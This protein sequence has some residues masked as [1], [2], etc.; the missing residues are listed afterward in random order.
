MRQATA[1]LLMAL[2]T[3]G[4]MSAANEIGMVTSTLD[5]V[6]D[7]NDAFLRLTG[8]TR[9]DLEAG[10]VHWRLLTAPEWTSMDDSAVDELR[11]TGSYGPHLKEYL[12]PDGTRL[13]VEVTSALLSP[14]PPSWVTFIRDPAAQP[15]SGTLADSAERLAVLA[16]ELGR[17]VTVTDV[18]R[19]LTR[20]VRQAMGAL[21][22]TI[23]VVDLAGQS[24]HPVLADEIPVPIA[25]GFRAFDTELD[26]PSTRA[27]RERRMGF[28]PDTQTTDKVFPH[29]A[30]VRAA[31]AV[32]SAMAVPLIAGAEITGVLT[33]YW[34]TPRELSPAERSFTDAVAGYAAQALARAQLFEAEQAA[35]ARLQALQV[36]T[37]GLATAVTSEQIAEVLVR[38]GMGI[39]AAHGVVAVLD[40]P[41]DHLRTWTTA[42]FPADIARI[43]A[44]IPVSSADD[45]PIGWTMRTGQTLIL[46]SL[47]EISARHPQVAYTHEATGTSS[48]LSV[49]VHA[50]GRTIGALAFGFSPE[51]TPGDDVI[52]VAE[53][54]AGLALERA[55]LYEIE[56]AAAH[57]LQQALL[58]TIPTGLPGVSIGAFYR[59]AE[60]GNEVG[61][62]WYDVFELP[63]GAVGDV[64]GHD[65]A[66]A[67]AMGRLQLLLRYTALGGAGPAG[68]LDALEAACPDLTGT[69]YAT[70]AY[71]EYDPA[72]PGGPHLTYAC[73]EHPPPLLAD[74]ETVRFLEGGR[75]GAL[76]FG[77]SRT[78]ARIAVPRPA[79]LV[80]Y[81][82]GLVERRGQT[83][84]AGFGRLA[85]AVAG[86]P[87]GG[88]TR[89]A[90]DRLLTIMTGTEVLADDV[91][92]ICI[93]LNGAQG[94]RARGR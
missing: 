94:R 53:T 75:S 91:A 71:A 50:G 92:L 27:W 57:Q 7:A 24:M 42:N 37:A 83:I 68:V 51:G 29:L 90:C 70:V 20:H 46:A 52:Q 64:V 87:D 82:D 34:S 55:R 21:G 38:E 41:G 74:G 15:D 44:R 28:Y 22:S 8:N 72:G 88:D 40:P 39:V 35:R 49:P 80:L 65:L 16:G 2:A 43:Y 25:Q 32:H 69:D 4:R 31:S 76:G 47:A 5:G 89:A 63:G 13:T 12:R 58:P 6:R 56:H 26:T 61:G 59:P 10:Q 84:D 48:L 86:L 77:G 79:R 67:V 81:T 78:Q 85:E 3:L 9:A 62:D 18:T 93:D 66:A 11:A 1:R 33:V 54:L 23:M 73:A 60:E 45:M 17:D 30:G 36:V 19:T 14:E